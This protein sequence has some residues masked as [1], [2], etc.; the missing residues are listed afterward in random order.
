MPGRFANKAGG[1]G[2]CAVPEGADSF[3][4]VVIGAGMAGA[5]VAAGLAARARVLLLEMERQPGYHTTG[6]SAAV[7]APIYGPQ[8]I[9]A[10]TRASEAFYRDP[11]EGFTDHPLFSPRSILM[12][13]REDQLGALEALMAELG[14]DGPVARLDAGETREAMPLL[15]EGYAAGAVHDPTGQDID[16]HALHQGYLRQV[17]SRGGRIET[18]AEAVRL[19]RS[20]G[21]WE[22][23]TSDAAFRAGTVVNAAGAWADA[24]GALAGAERIGLVP[25]RRTALMVPAPEGRVLEGLPITVDIEEQFYLKPDAGR[26]L[27]SPANEDPEAPCDVQ[28]DE[29]DIAICIDRIERAFD[30]SVRRIET[31]W[32]GLRSFVA[33]KCPVAGFSD[34]VEGFYWLAGQGGYGIQTAPA[35]SEFAAAELLGDAVP[36]HIL[37][38]RF[39]P[40]TVRP[41]RE[42]IGG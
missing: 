31:K 30:L 2:E 23:A 16:V 21:A 40:A 28:P 22:I 19:T 36:G 13:A 41:G 11:P 33:D 39:D 25:K 14:S 34:R 9:R 38:E 3:D 24:V 42:G 8:P 10:L 32:A 15:R 26:L 18:E 5:S 4:F 29:M 35:L 37:E 17:R 7:F 1:Q 12:A 27:I 6:R 20:G